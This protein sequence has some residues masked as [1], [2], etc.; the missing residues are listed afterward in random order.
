M[1]THMPRRRRCTAERVGLQRPC[2]QRPP[3]LRE[4]AQPSKRQIAWSSSF[5]AKVSGTAEAELTAA[6]AKTNVKWAD[7]AVIWPGG[8]DA[9]VEVKAIPVL[10]PAKLQAVVTDLAALLAVDWPATLQHP[11]AGCRGGRA[12]VAGPPRPDRTMGTKHRP[13]P[14]GNTPARWNGLDRRS[15]ERRARCS[16]AA[17]PR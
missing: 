4:P 2:R 9:L 12:L 7:G 16:P 5:Q 15:A 8:T 17:V 14:R 11:G 10:R 6:N 13:A 3:D 1:R